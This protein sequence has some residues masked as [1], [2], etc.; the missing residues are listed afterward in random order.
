MRLRDEVRQLTA[1]LE[2]AQ[3]NVEKLREPLR[4]VSRELV[5]SKDSLLIAQVS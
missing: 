5:K 2:E 4:K 1:Q 3:R